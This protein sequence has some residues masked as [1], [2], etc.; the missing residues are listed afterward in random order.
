VTKE[1]RLETDRLVL[2]DW[3][4][5]VV[6]LAVSGNEASWGLMRRLGM[7]RR[8]DL[9]FDSP[10]FDPEKPRIIACSIDREGRA[11]THG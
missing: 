3:R 7:R 8:K 2:R 1:F 11:A 10:D 6:A 4:D 9:D 5:E